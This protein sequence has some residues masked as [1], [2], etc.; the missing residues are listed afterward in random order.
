MRFFDPENLSNPRS[1][2]ALGLVATLFAYMLS[3]KIGPWTHFAFPSMV[4]WVF[5]VFAL[6]AWNYKREVAPVLC[7]LLFAVLATLRYENSKEVNIDLGIPRNMPAREITADLRIDRIYGDPTQQNRLRGIGTLTD[8]PIEQDYLEKRKIYFYLSSSAMGDIRIAEGKHWRARGIVKRLSSGS[9]SQF[10]ETQGVGYSIHIDKIEAPPEALGGIHSITAVLSNVRL[11]WIERLQSYF[12]GRPETAAVLIA[13][14]L[15][16][17]RYLSDNVHTAFFETGTLHLFAISGLHIMAIFGMLRQSLRLINIPT[18][19]SS[20]GAL[21]IT[22][23]FILL[24]G[25]PPSAIRAFAILLFL[26]SSKILQRRQ[27]NFASMVACALVYVWVSPSAIHSLGFALSFSVVAAILLI[28]VPLRDLADKW[29]LAYEAPRVSRLRKWYRRKVKRGIVDSFCISISGF[30]GSAPWILAQ[31]GSITPF[32]ILANTFL[33]V[34]GMW[35][36]FV[37]IAISPLVMLFESCAHLFAIPA[38]G[39]QAAIEITQ[40]WSSWPIAFSTQ[41]IAE[42]YHLPL[43]S[44]LVGFGYLYNL[45]IRLIKIKMLHLACGCIPVFLYTITYPLQLKAFGALP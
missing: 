42:T 44:L 19:W 4:L 23:I 32:G 11:L 39:A 36:L 21:A 40:S 25:C 24:T 9:F 29:M 18:R 15:G 45:R 35:T 17:T 7:F 34:V 27:E 38:I 31:F 28:G 30:I 10:L 6:I 26:Y 8:V 14:S 41:R 13:L 33:V 22:G 16:D 3:S 37:L 2:L 43:I 1:P 20:L 12:Q 5:T